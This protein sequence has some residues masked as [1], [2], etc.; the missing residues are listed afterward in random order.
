M[1]L[2]RGTF[3]FQ[4]VSKRGWI[5]DT[6]NKAR[7]IA[8]LILSK[9]KDLSSIQIPD[10]YKR[11]VFLIVG[12]EYVRRGDVAHGLTI[13]NQ[14]KQL[15]G[16][17]YMD[18]VAHIAFEKIKS[19]KVD[20]GISILDQLEKMGYS[21]DFER[22]I[23][24]QDLVEMTR[25]YLIE[26]DFNYGFRMLDILHR[27]GGDYYVRFAADVAFMKIKENNLTTGIEILKRVKGIAGDEAIITLE[28]V[29]LNKL[30][31]KELDE[32][33]TLLEQSIGL[34]G[35]KYL[36]RAADIGYAFLSSGDVESGS[37]IIALIKKLGGHV[38]DSIAQLI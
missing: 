11:D 8:N 36:D 37:R 12:L 2:C 13:L 28:D 18:T 3:V 33:L 22:F 25:T 20:L 27:I 24:I 19:K 38:D 1:Y 10:Q 17:D 14:C 7:I 6:D 32:G 34:V 31:R 4:G 26:N 16:P 35:P 21:I 9:N 23:D 29:V 15:G 5:L 30:K